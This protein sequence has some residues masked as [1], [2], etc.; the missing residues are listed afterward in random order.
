M[1]GDGVSCVAL[2]LQAAVTPEVSQ[3][4]SQNAS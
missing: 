4:L 1:A 2:S 3:E